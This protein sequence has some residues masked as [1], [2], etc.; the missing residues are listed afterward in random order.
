VLMNRRPRASYVAGGA[1]S[2]LETILL[3]LVVGNASVL[4]IALWG[5]HR[6]PRLR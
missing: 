1:D 6:G 3:L 4:V 2:M 5:A